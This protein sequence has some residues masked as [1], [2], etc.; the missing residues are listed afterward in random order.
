[1][2]AASAAHMWEA[3][4]SRYDI[5]VIGGGPA[6]ITATA[7]ALHAQLNLV[8]I[9]PEIGGR[10]EHHFSLRDQPHI[11]TVWGADVVHQFA[12]YAGSMP[13]THR[14]EEA[15]HVSIRDRGFRVELDDGEYVYARTVIVATGAHPRRL[16]LPGEDAFRGRGISYSALSHAPLFISRDVAIVG[17]GTRAVQAVFEVA[18]LAAHVSFIVPEW[19]MLTSPLLEKVLAHPK[20]DVYRNWHA[21]AIIG[22]SFVTG[23]EVSSA[24]G[25]TRRLDADGVFFQ[26][27]LIPNSGCVHG[28]VDLD[29]YER[30]VINQRCETNVPGLFAAGDVTTVAGEQVPIAIGEGAKA[31][32][33]AWEYLVTPQV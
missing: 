8:L 28:V 3:T 14:T 17:N 24:E 2:P 27:A 13:L 12:G 4:V 25:E 30:I 10:I 19:D 22:D 16:H 6:G 23:I 7:Y 5:A 29:R 9:A 26:F 1:M 20:V 32:L 18:S 11:D 31:A 21:H 33:G 15:A